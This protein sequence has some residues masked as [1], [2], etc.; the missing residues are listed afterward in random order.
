[1]LIKGAA[2]EDRYRVHW[3]IEGYQGKGILTWP[4]GSRYE[5]EFY[6]GRLQGEGTFTWP[7]GSSY[8]G[9]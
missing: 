9:E 2:E 6:D 7:D 5:G 3:A 8:N 1:M 4:D